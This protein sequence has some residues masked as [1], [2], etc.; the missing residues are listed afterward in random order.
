MWKQ[1]IDFG[2][3]LISINRKTE[4]H[5]EDLKTLRQDIKEIRQELR[6]IAESLQQVRFDQQRDRE[7]AA[8]DRKILLLEVHNALLR[9]ERRLPPGHQNDNELEA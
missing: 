7:N 4:E 1:L 3:R 9:Y 5:G 2:Q 8:A 6:M